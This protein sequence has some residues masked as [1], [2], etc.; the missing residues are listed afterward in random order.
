MGG[1]KQERGEELA[2]ELAGHVLGLLFNGSL[3]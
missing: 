1:F 2:G 3:S